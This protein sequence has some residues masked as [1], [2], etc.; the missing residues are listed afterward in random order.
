MT[1]ATNESRLSDKEEQRYNELVA[2]KSKAGLSSQDKRELHLLTNKKF[3]ISKDNMAYDPGAHALAEEI[4]GQAQVNISGIDDDK[5]F[6]AVSDEYI[7]EH[8]PAIGDNF[9]SRFK[10]R[11]RRVFRAAR[12][13]GRKVYYRFD[14]R[15]GNRVLEKLRQYESEYDVKVTIKF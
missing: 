7:G 8:K 6:D 11:S 15:S 9:G 13:T 4:G 10:N 3:P 1:D 2:K 5:E 12:M 14:G